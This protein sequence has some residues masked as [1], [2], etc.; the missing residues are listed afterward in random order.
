MVAILLSP[1]QLGMDP[2][3]KAV[4]YLLYLIFVVGTGVYW[5]ERQYTKQINTPS[6]I[7]DNRVC[8]YGYSVSEA[9]GWGLIGLVFIGLFL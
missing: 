3:D 7:I 2:M 8:C 9:T 1:I 5:A 6:G 4:F